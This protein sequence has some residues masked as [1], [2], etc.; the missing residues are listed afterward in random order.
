MV[1][2]PASPRVPTEAAVKLLFNADAIV[3]PL[4]GIGHY[5]H[6][7]LR[8]L[9]QRPD[10]VDVRAFSAMRWLA[11][12]EDP[13]Q[14]NAG[15]QRG[16]HWLPF[17]ALALQAYL[18]LRDR[19]F[20]R[21]ARDFPDAILH[22]PNFLDLP[23]R[24][25]RV[26]TIHDMAYARYPHTLPAARLK[27][28]QQRVPAAAAR[29]DAI[30]VPSRFVKDEVRELL[31]VP[32][33]RI[34]VVAHGVNDSFHAIGRQQETGDLPPAGILSQ[35]N[36]Q[37]RRYV[38]CVA[39]PEPR[40]NLM[41]L[42][43][44]WFLLPANVRQRHS[45][46]L[47]GAAGWKNHDLARRLAFIAP[48]AAEF[49]RVLTPGYVPADQLPALYAHA[50]GLIMPSVYE[51]FGLP[52]AEAMAAGLPTA[53]AHG[54][55]LDELASAPTLRFQ[56]HDLAAMSRALQAL[57]EDAD[58]R[59]ECAAA[60][61]QLARGLRWQTCAENTLAVYRSLASGTACGYNISLS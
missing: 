1:E 40:K 3:A 58:W 24:G 56:A 34:H 39:T 21:L 18:Q 46:V 7:L 45:L 36:L 37:P 33:Q 31:P 23:H 10:A 35:L 42:L 49:G 50:A 48:R 41:S 11:R 15:L 44:A 54:S 2:R 51:G 5:A 29:A 27:L 13:L 26:I 22:S 4:T 59:A 28:L 16:R 12:G 30:I 9:R 32:Q 20:Q 14:A 6:E 53:A 61:R 43:D 25:P 60:N 38:L 47:V 57:L 55:A 8:A 17:P 19:R 52:L